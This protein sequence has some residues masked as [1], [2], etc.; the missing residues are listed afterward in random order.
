M[1]HQNKCPLPCKQG[2]REM[3]YEFMKTCSPRRRCHF[4][5]WIVIN[6][7]VSR[8]EFRDISYTFQQLLEKDHALGT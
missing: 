6:R 2:F 5:Y 3:R 1:L 7:N 4:H 8:Q